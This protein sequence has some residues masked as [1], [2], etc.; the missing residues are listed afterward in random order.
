MQKMEYFSKIPS[1]DSGMGT[2]INEKGVLI[3]QNICGENNF[4]SSRP[5]ESRNIL[6]NF[7]ERGALC[8]QRSQKQT[9][10]DFFWEQFHSPQP[11]KCQGHSCHLGSQPQVTRQPYG[12]HLGCFD[13]YM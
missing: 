12:I 6:T 13:V 2:S 8:F 10:F 9:I 4:I 11:I 5:V 7:C 1:C 3:L